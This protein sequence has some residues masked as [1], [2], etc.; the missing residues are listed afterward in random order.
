MTE[1]II[2]L[3]VKGGDAEKIV[4]V[5]C[6]KCRVVR[7]DR[8]TAERCCKLHDCDLCGA[9]CERPWTRCAKCRQTER[10]KDYARKRAKAF[11]AANKVLAKDYPHDQVCLSFWPDESDYY[12]LGEWDD[13]P[14]EH[15]WVWGC[16]PMPW[17]RP[18]M[19]DIMSNLL[20]DFPERAIED[21][22]DLN[23]LQ[24]VVEEWFDQHASDP[25][26]YWMIDKRTVVV[27]DVANTPDRLEAPDE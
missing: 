22:P 25:S 21:L 16:T 3:V 19:D 14:D 27:L 11:N 9:T 4:A 6:G 12:V 20:D 18:M 17:P 5:A 15:P 1:P 8:A 13:E 26:G 10:D 24:S 2:E 7:I 23:G